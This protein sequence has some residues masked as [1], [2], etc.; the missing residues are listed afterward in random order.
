[1]SKS[2]AVDNLE[3]LHIIEVMEGFLERMR[4]PEQMR[5]QLDI[6][7]KIDGQSVIIH[8]IRHYWD[9]P[10]RIIYPDVAKAT[11]VKGKN[12]WKVFWQ[13]ANLKWYPYDPKPTVTSLKDFV[14]LV[15]EDKLHCFWG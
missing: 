14:K 2:Y 10:P 15:E 13:R 6:G 11:F 7:Y 5:A 3:L 1:M 12:H 9:H 4:P 8:E